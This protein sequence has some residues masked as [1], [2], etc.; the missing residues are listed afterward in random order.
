[1]RWVQRSLQ[2]E[3]VQRSSQGLGVVVKVACSH[4]ILCIF[5]HTLHLQVFHM[6]K[7]AKL[8]G[9]SIIAYLQQKG[10]PEVSLLFVPVSLCDL[11]WQLV[12]LFVSGGLAG[13]SSL[14]EG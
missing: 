1:M 6:V 14:C 5:L 2:C 11:V 13:G 4:I 12:W 9:Q 3:G 8:V 7:T 10:Y